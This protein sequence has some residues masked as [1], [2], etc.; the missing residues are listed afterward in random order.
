MIILIFLINVKG[1]LDEYAY[2]NCNCIH[3]SH[4]TFIAWLITNFPYIPCLRKNE[5]RNIINALKI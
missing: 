2:E 4:S 3:R 5:S 1:V